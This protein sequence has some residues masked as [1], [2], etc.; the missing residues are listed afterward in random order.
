[1]SI[2]RSIRPRGR[3]ELSDLSSTYLFAARHTNT[4]A[5]PSRAPA[6]PLSCCTSQCRSFVSLNDLAKLSPFSTGNE[7]G[8]S[9]EGFESYSEE[10]KLPFPQ[11]H[12]FDV[13]ADVAK[14]EQ[15]VPYCLESRIVDRPTDG[16][17]NKDT[18]QF[19]AELTVGF[20]SIQ[21]RYTSKVTLVDAHKVVAEA[22]P[23]PLFQHLRTSWTLEPV[24]QNETRVK[25][26]I[27]YAFSNPLYAVMAKKAMHKMSSQMIGAF[28]RRAEELA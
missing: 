10:V 26:A 8:S 3:L 5:G 1:M 11:R 12:L 28:R 16:E 27:E 23:T 9:A 22:V 20:G 18:K 25:L 14:Y 13:I 7:G 15:F 6:N 21:E 24:T 2:A 19:H 17:S 4:H